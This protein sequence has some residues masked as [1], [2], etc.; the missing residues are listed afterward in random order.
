M[1]SSESSVSLRLE[2]KS[3]PIAGA[4]G[5]AFGMLPAALAAFSAVEAAASGASA[6]SI[7][8]ISSARLVTDFGR[9]ASRATWMPYDLSAA[10]GTMRRRKAT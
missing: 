1:T 2:A 8:R 7:A 5:S 4:A 3:E 6:S 9:P 10:P